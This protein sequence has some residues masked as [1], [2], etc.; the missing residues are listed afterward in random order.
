MLAVYPNSSG[1]VWTECFSCGSWHKQ[2]TGPDNPWVLNTK[3]SC[4]GQHICVMD[5]GKF[6][7]VPGR[8]RLK[9]THHTHA[10]TYINVNDY[11]LSAMIFHKFSKYRKWWQHEYLHPIHWIR[12]QISLN[13]EAKI[14]QICYI[15]IQQ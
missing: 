2:S 3:V 4:L 5:S 7:T 12:C 14:H 15:I 6:E 9:H 13:E 10:C 1:F 11:Q 8:T